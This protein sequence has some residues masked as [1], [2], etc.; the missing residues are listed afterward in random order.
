MEKADFSGLT[1]QGEKQESS[2]TE[3]NGKNYSFFVF[4]SS[5]SSHER[6]F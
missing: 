6:V 2:S 4:N 3:K 5:S 1:E